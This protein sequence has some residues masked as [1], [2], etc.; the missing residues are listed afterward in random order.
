MKMKTIM[1]I[2]VFLLLQVLVFTEC[3]DGSFWVE[4]R[5]EPPTKD[6]S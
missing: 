2:R 5:G 3:R 6:A 1:L 4:S